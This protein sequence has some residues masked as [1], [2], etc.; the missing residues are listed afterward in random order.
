MNKKAV[1]IIIALL[2]FTANINFA[3]LSKT[4]QKETIKYSSQAITFVNKYSTKKS[5]NI[6][7]S[8]QNKI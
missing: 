2:M 3:Y 4:Q 8:R 6:V 7:C 1:I 5:E